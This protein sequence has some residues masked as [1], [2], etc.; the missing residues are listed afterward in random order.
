MAQQ[1]KHGR[2]Y[3]APPPTATVSVMVEKGFN[4]KPFPNASVVFPGD[5]RRQDYGQPGDENGSGMERLRWI[6]WK[7]EAM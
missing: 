1:E 3:K 6:C 7:W 5:A 2:G 4:E